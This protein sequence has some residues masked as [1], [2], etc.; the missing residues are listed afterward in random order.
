MQTRNMQSWISITI[1]TFAFLSLFQHTISKC[2]TGCLRCDKNG[3]CLLCDQSRYY[4][5]N[6]FLNCVLQEIPNCL[7][8]TKTGTCLLC[9]IDHY[10]DTVLNQCVKMPMANKI[11]RCLYYSDLFNCEQCEEFFY[12]K[13]SKCVEVE[14]NI[15]NCI[16]YRANNSEICLMCKEGWV[17]SHDGSNCIEVVPIDNCAS[18][19]VQNC[20]GCKDGSHSNQSAYLNSLNN[21]NNENAITTFNDYLVKN[22]MNIWDPINFSQCETVLVSNCKKTHSVFECDVCD[23]GYFLGGDGQ[24][25]ENPQEAINFCTEYQ[26]Q[27]YCLT[28]AQGYYPEKTNL[29]SPIP[30]IENCDEYSQYS[31]QCKIC[32]SA[33]Y[34]NGDKCE[35]RTQ[36]L[37]IDL[38]ITRSLDSDTCSECQKG[39]VPTDDGLKCLSIIPNCQTYKAMDQNFSR[40]ICYR[41]DQGFYLDEDINEC[42]FPSVRDHGCSI[43]QRAFQKC[44]VC[45][46]GYYL[47]TQFNCLKHNQDLIS[48][49]C[50]EPSKTEANTCATCLEGYT[51]FFSL[52]TCQL[53]T[54]PISFCQVYKTQEDCLTCEEGYYPPECNTIPA[55]E[56]CLVRKYLDTQCEKCKSGYF[57]DSNGACLLPEDSV[58]VGC[59]TIEINP[60]D[61]FT[62]KACQNSYFFKKFENTFICDS[63]VSTVDNCI[64]YKEK[65]SVVGGYE[66]L[67][68]QEGYVLDYETMTCR[69]SCPNERPLLSKQMVDGNQNITYINRCIGQ[70]PHTGCRVLA[71]PHWDTTGSFADACVQCDLN[72]FHYLDF[73]ANA[74]N[75]TSFHGFDF[76]GLIT[77]LNISQVTKHN[78]IKC[79]NLTVLNTDNLTTN[80]TPSTGCQ[81][82]A[83]YEGKFVCIKCAHGFSGIVEKYEASAGNFVWGIANCVEIS[84]CITEITSY[85]GIGWELASSNLNF[86][87]TSFLTCSRCT[88]NKIPF[89]H[90]SLTS[91]S[92]LTAYNIIGDIPSAGADTTGMSVVCRDV[93]VP[94]E[95]GVTTDVTFIQNCGVAIWL[96]D[97]DRATVTDPYYCVT[98]KPGFAAT[99]STDAGKEWAITSCDA[100][101]YCDSLKGGEWFSSCSKCSSGK[102][103]TY[104]KDTDTNKGH[105]NYGLCTENTLGDANCDLVD[106]TGACLLCRKGAFLNEDG[107]CENFYATD[108]DMAY[109]YKWLGDTVA[110]NPTYAPA[111]EFL[112]LIHEPLGMGCTSC[113]NSKFALF[114]ATPLQICTFSDYIATDSFPLSTVFISNCINYSYNIS[115]SRHTCNGCKS[116]FRLIA[117]GTKCISKDIVKGCMIYSNNETGCDECEEGYTTFGNKCFENNISNC[118]E[119]S[120]DHNSVTNT[121]TLTCLECA[122]TFYILN[123]EC[124][125][126]QV[127]NC[128][129]YYTTGDPYACKTCQDK[130]GLF[131]TSENRAVCLGFDN[132]SQRTFCNKWNTLTNGEK[133]YC[134]ECQFGYT[135]V[136]NLNLTEYANNMCIGPVK[137]LNC[138]KYDIKS[139]PK[140]SSYLCIECNSSYFVNEG[141]CVKRTTIQKCNAWVV[142]KD[143]CSSCESG[144]FLSED[145]RSCEA[146]PQGIQGCSVYL[147]ES[148]CQ[149]C[150]S[151]YYLNEQQCLTVPEEN[152]VPFCSE[153]DSNQVCQACLSGFF[154]KLAKCEKADVLNCKV[155][156]DKDNCKECEEPFG[157]TLTDG[158]A[159]CVNKDIPNC[160]RA[161]DYSPFKCLSC[162]NTYYSNFGICKK[163]SKTIDYCIE[164]ESDDRCR[165]CDEFSSISQNGSECIK[166][167]YIVKAVDSGCKYKS[168]VS[169]ICNTCNLGYYLFENGCRKCEGNGSFESGCAFCDP[170]NPEV[171]WMCQSGYYYIGTSGV[172][173]KEKDLNGGDDKSVKLVQSHMMLVLVFWLF[174]LRK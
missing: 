50:D 8:A 3:D 143:L 151:G 49:A 156:Q 112:T 27:D 152:L 114:Q 147:S 9:D 116:E 61:S 30:K 105:I 161:T 150:K 111:P 48:L 95:F 164:Y 78:F 24:C 7:Q 2:G 124:K 117:N 77:D 100:I 131:Y 98:C 29:C 39:F 138:L 130:Y 65:A 12:V 10:L 5:L 142:D 54:N 87:M 66:C 148:Q 109:D 134:S 104:S 36:S 88:G 15:V 155:Y 72:A 80:A 162:Q 170:Q 86:S 168:I 31:P 107:K 21:M 75:L 125:P 154:L 103:W 140:N 1:C 115:D 141:S 128:K 92:K 55:N 18:Y 157:L 165:Y 73:S 81:L 90:V 20:L 16:K 119:F 108:C 70:S 172:C 149:K 68:C 110:S 174:M 28:C 52:T 34:L 40:A 43:F 106:S 14:K 62:C 6:S 153:Y 167:E 166:D 35:K 144:Y 64:R 82:Y 58:K 173:E 4:F 83:I 32:K 132:D 79:S 85:E 84:N 22:K 133:F 101:A 74:M 59:Q 41:C 169:P 126:G 51:Q 113:K 96:V 33:F 122:D 158:K 93:S 37:Y 25:F 102:N 97:E 135:L 136:E 60:D 76:S 38:C 129:E 127:N 94:V 56:N 171:C 42:I 44:D 139:E 160:Q 19:S 71:K 13:D 63:S 159:V 11:N 26:S 57:L 146:F 53:I 69:I 121:N 17:A 89:L 67:R 163:A 45:Q 46:E 120:V 118:L 99:F 145:Q 23:D 47:D 123:D 137:I 91:P